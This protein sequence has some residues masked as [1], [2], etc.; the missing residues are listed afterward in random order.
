[1]MAPIVSSKA[2]AGEPSLTGDVDLDLVVEFAD[3]FF[4]QLGEAGGGVVGRG[5][6]LSLNERAR[7][8]AMFQEWREGEWEVCG[9][10]VVDFAQC[11]IKQG[12][13]RTL[14]L[15]NRQLQ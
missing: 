11:D 8:C 13:M 1:M 7:R 12:G 6:V 3:T 15:R 14:A 4:Y 10:R 5:N 9:V 2:S